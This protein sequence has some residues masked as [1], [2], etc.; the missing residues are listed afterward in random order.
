MPLNRIG[1]PGIG[2]RL[3]QARLNAGLTQTTAAQL[4]GVSWMSIHRGEHEIRSVSLAHLERLAT[5]YGASVRWLMTIE[6]GDI[7]GDGEPEEVSESA[8][9][10]YYRVAL[11]T[12]EVQLAVEKVID[13][14]LNEL[15]KA[16][17]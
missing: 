13:G 14:I 8:R 16:E 1:I 5:I 11:S 6:E 2:R 3:R 10:I 9:R 4:S 7:I 15:E 12:L 17:G